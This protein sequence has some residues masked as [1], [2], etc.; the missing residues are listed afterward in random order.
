MKGNDFGEKLHYHAG[1]G[2]VFNIPGHFFCFQ[3][4]LCKG[5]QQASRG[6]IKPRV[7]HIVGRYVLTKRQRAQLKAQN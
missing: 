7:T 4:F 6:N 1:S 2:V 5:K 3:F